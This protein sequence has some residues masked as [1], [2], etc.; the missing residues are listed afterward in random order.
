M[1]VRGTGCLVI[2][3]GGGDVLGSSAGLLTRA[4]GP[5]RESCSSGRLPSLRQS[6]VSV[7][8]LSGVPEESFVDMVLV[9]LSIILSLAEEGGAGMPTCPLEPWGHDSWVRSEQACHHWSETSG[10]TAEC[11][12]W[13]AGPTRFLQFS[14]DLRSRSLW[15]LAC[16]WLLSAPH[17][18]LPFFCVLSHDRQDWLAVRVW[19]FE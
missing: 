16:S 2:Y 3:R 9:F 10:C 18:F 12:N 6:R 14:E 19:R 13:V 8:W 1:L 4:L 15:S 11:V 7:G 17:S 5:L